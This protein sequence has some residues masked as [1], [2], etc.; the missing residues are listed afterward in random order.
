MIIGAFGVVVSIS[1]FGVLTFILFLL[2]GII[3]FT[4][5]KEQVT[6]PPVAG[7]NAG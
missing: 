2:G 6:A 4:Q 7:Q 5:K 3:I 1:I